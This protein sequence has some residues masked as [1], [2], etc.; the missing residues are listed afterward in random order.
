[1]LISQ[2]TNKW[3]GFKIFIISADMITFATVFQ[4]FNITV[5]CQFLFVNNVE[6]TG[7]DMSTGY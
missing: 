1:M 3:S 6:Y 5:I 4:I 2:F 7:L